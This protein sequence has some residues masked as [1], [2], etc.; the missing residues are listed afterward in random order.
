MVLTGRIAT[1][2][3]FAESSAKFAFT[4]GL[5]KLPI[6]FNLKWTRPD[7]VCTGLSEAG[8][9][10]DILLGKD[11]GADRTREAVFLCFVSVDFLRSAM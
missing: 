2:A 3:C 5:N 8:P 9:S 4:A 10:K 6:E 1:S 7:G 11:A